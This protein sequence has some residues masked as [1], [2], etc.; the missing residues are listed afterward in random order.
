MKCVFWKKAGVE[1]S[2]KSLPQFKYTNKRKKI[3]TTCSPVAIVDRSHYLTKEESCNIKSSETRLLPTSKRDKMTVVVNVIQQNDEFTINRRQT[4]ATRRQLQN[5]N[6]DNSN[7]ND[8]IAVEEEEELDDDDDDEEE[9][10]EEKKQEKTF[11]NHTK[12]AT[13]MTMT[14]ACND[15]MRSLTKNE[16]INPNTSDNNY[17]EEEEEEEKKENLLKHGK[18]ERHDDNNDN[19]FPY[20]PPP[21]PPPLLQSVGRLSPSRVDGSV[22]IHHPE[23]APL[24]LLFDNNESTQIVHCECTVESLLLIKQQQQQQQHKLTS[25]GGSNPCA[26]RRS[27]KAASSCSANGAV[28]R[29]CDSKIACKC[30]RYAEQC[31][32]G[33]ACA[34]PS[35]TTPDDVPPFQSDHHHHT[36]PTPFS[37]CYYSNNVADNYVDADDDDY[38]NGASN[39]D[40][41]DE[42]NH[43]YR[44]EKRRQK[45]S[46]PKACCSNR[47]PM[48]ANENMC[49]SLSLDDNNPTVNH[50]GHHHP[51]QQQHQ[52]QQQQLNELETTSVVKPNQLDIRCKCRHG[53]GKK[54]CL[55]SSK[56]A[57]RRVFKVCDQQNCKCTANCANVAAHSTH[58][59][60][61]AQHALNEQVQ[62]W[63][64]EPHRG[65]S[66]V[67]VAKLVSDQQVYTADYF[68]GDGKEPRQHVEQIFY[69]ELMNAVDQCQMATLR[70][71]CLFMP[72]SPCF[73]QDCEPQC[74]VLD[75]CQSS[76]A[77]AETLA[78]V[79]KQLQQRLNNSDLQMT[80]KFLASYVRRGDLYTKQ[81]ILCMLQ[82]GISV[83]PLNRKDWQALVEPDD[84]Q[85]SR[86]T[87]ALLWDSLGLT[88]YAMQSQFYINECRQELGLRQLYW[89]S[90]LHTLLRDCA[91]A[92]TRCCRNFGQIRRQF[93]HEQSRGDFERARRRHRSSLNLVH[94]RS[95]SVE[96]SLSRC[97][98]FNNNNNNNNNSF[99]QQQQHNFQNIQDRSS[100]ALLVDS[101]WTRSSNECDSSSLLTSHL[102]QKQQQQH[103]S[104]HTLLQNSNTPAPSCSILPSYCSSAALIWPTDQTS[105]HQLIDNL[106]GRCIDELE[107]QEIN[108]EVMKAIDEIQLKI[109]DLLTYLHRTIDS[110]AL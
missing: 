65:A 64:L 69:T 110:T 24:M 38:D 30:R 49:Y 71:I 36:N 10:E 82:A 106:Q 53:S 8:N 54:R 50:T 59:D 57:C 85:R 84:Q 22:E 47:M 12:H 103:R 55:D 48:L 21:P 66:R 109:A 61:I 31:H 77:C 86:H 75:R 23:P 18:H 74:D 26:G 62:K 72:T 73:H 78:I 16:Q 52:Q 17:E 43:F 89:H 28:I 58:R 91:V 44:G 34:R 104:H 107:A 19:G 67:M 6:Y 14:T 70:Q 68:V 32:S 80:V 94:L 42:I 45:S 2:K 25:G 9:E 37:R 39:Y 1:P 11:D 108:T 105:I 7:T 88:N 51:Q 92:G 33:C 4:D 79:Y 20:A 29:L 95:Q 56:C 60:S 81:G 100:T 41:D 40:Y 87:R 46:L 63:F 27:R 102:Q 13:M 35:L 83:E 96:S 15:E 93:S 97:S 99:Q 98:R 5:Y 101:A 76:R 90:A 3:I